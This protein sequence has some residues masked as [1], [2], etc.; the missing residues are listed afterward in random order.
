MALTNPQILRKMKIDSLL[1]RFRHLIVF[2]IGITIQ[3][4]MLFFNLSESDAFRFSQTTFVVREYVNNGIDLRMPLPL[5]GTNS[6]MPMEFPLFQIVASLL[7]SVLNLD[8]LVA[9]RLAGLIF[10]QGTGLLV[11]LLSK[12]WFDGNVAFYAL[13]VFQFLPFGLRNAHSPL[14]EFMSVFFLL[15]AVYL[16]D[17]IVLRKEIS[18][19]ITFTILA[20]AS[21]ILGFLVKV[22]S[23]VA[24]LPLLAIPVIAIF[25]SKVRLIWKLLQLFSVSTAIFLS[26]LSVYFW[27]SCADETKKS[28]PYTSNL[29]ST[30]MHEWNFG[31]LQD[32]LDPKTW[33]TIYFQHL[34][35]ITSGLFA[36]AIFMFFSFKIYGVIRILPLA[37]SVFFGPIMFV[38]LYRGHGYYIAAIYPVL[39]VLVAVGISGFTKM[40]SIKPSKHAFFMIG[41]LIATSFS[42]KIGLNYASDIFN[43][44]DIPRLSYEVRTEVPPTG[45]VMYLGCDWNPEIPFYS[46]RESLMVPEWDIA[47]LNRDLIRVSHVAFCDFVLVDRGEKLE[48]FFAD[49]SKILKV[50]ENIY[51]VK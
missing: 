43:H 1:S 10:F 36:L 25:R 31:T 16:F 49:N 46:N 33:I 4:P 38:S 37:V 18:H 45:Y 51:S 9:T 14:I 17:T 11:Y 21:L 5:F 20:S 22:T 30:K 34:G 12:K 42:T 15:S 24:L 19:Q 40:F 47:P 26:V 27:N 3:I 7:S 28:N 29:L 23:G 41:F 6:F 48:E 39:V 2:V 35:P 32:R 50:S 8:P 44:S 13:I